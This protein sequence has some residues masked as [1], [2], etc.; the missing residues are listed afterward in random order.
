MFTDET[1]YSPVIAMVDNNI[2]SVIIISIGSIFGKRRTGEGIY[3]GDRGTEG[4]ASRER[5]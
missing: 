2:I 1:M 4:I 3:I 5:G